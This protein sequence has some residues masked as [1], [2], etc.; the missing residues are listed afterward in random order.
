MAARMQGMMRYDG[1]LLLTVPPDS[2]ERAPRLR[3]LYP[4]DLAKGGIPIDVPVE[5]AIHEVTLRL[6]EELSLQGKR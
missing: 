6:A 5:G 1:R 3:E 2:F 4:V